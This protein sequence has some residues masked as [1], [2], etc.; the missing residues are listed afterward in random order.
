MIALC[1]PSWERLQEAKQVIQQAKQ[2][3]LAFHVVGI[4]KILDV[5][6][7]LVGRRDGFVTVLLEVDVEVELLQLRIIEERLA[8]RDRIVRRVVTPTAHKPQQARRECKKCVQLIAARKPGN[9]DNSKT[10]QE[11]QGL[12]RLQ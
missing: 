12:H 10:V 3:S 8:G 4:N 7:Q 1:S 6:E 2:K 5:L 9:D 11:K